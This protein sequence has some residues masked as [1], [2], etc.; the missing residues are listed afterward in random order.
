MSILFFCYLFFYMILLVYVY[1][2]LIFM[3]EINIAIKNNK[4]S[5]FSSIIFLT[6]VLV[7][8]IA[9]YFYNN[10]SLSEIEKL[11][12]NISSID[13]NISEVE[14]DKTLQVYSL[15]ELNKQTIKSYE[16][17]NNVSKFINHM[18]VIEGKYNLIF[19]WFDLS[20]GEIKSNIKVSSDDQWVIAYTKAKDFISKYRIDSKALFDLWFI[21][22]IE[23]M[24][25]MQFKVNFKIK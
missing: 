21:T 23:W 16:D 14:K 19:S 20:N 17:M 11:K 24:D 10:Y 13:S 2:K 8:T 5:Y 3:N 12:I 9:L 4:T 7:V 6:I 22:S 1:F 18:N 15:L 25:D